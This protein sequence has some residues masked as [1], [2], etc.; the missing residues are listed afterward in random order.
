MKRKT[1]GFG[2]GAK[3]DNGRKRDKLRRKKEPF[4][5][6]QRTKK[7]KGEEAVQTLARRPENTRREMIDVAAKYNLTKAVDISKFNRRFVTPPLEAAERPAGEFSPEKNPAID[8]RDREMSSVADYADEIR[9]NWERGVEAFMHIAGL[10][11]EANARLTP[12]QKSELMAYLPFGEVTFSKFAQIGSDTRLYAPDIQRLLPPHYTTVYAVTLLTDEELRQAIAENVIRPDMKRVHL[13]KWRNSRERLTPSPKEAESGSAVA[14][15]PTASTQ[16]AAESGVFTSALSQH[17]I[18]KNSAQNELAA[19]PK[20]AP[21][22]QAVATAA[23]VAG[24]FTPPPNDDDIP[25]LLDRR[26]LSPE[27]Q[28]AYDAIMAALNA[29]SAVVRGRVRAE[30]MRES[31]SSRSATPP[32]SRSGDDDSAIPNPPTKS[33]VPA[34]T[35]DGHVRPK[36]RSRKARGFQDDAPF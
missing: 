4:S 31:R 17:E 23:V 25:A 22:P 7:T 21:E 18:Q 14:S 33:V 15:P 1:R 9:G 34:H 10:C 6:L 35:A 32:S 2:F 24:P 30:L 5:K 11:A 8:L 19:A 29:A 13:Q 26:P 16:D 3:T 28:R 27:D 20:D 12:A 36:R